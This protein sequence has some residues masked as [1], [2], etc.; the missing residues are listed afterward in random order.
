MN[1]IVAAVVFER[2]HEPLLARRQFIARQIA[3]AVGAAA[4]SL[5]SLAVGAVGY[6]WAEDLRWLDAVHHAAMILTGMGPVTVMRSDVGKVFETIYALF[7]GVVFLSAAALLLAPVT[8]RLLHRFHIEA[9][10]EASGGA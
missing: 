6:R 8:H 7:S 9:D 1:A 5:G 4:L 3:W 10:E 2:R